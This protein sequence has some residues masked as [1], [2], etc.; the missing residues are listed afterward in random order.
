MRAPTFFTCL[1]FLFFSFFAIVVALPAE[2]VNAAVARA[3]LTGVFDKVLDARDTAKLPKSNDTVDST[4]GK[5]AAAGSDNR[6]ACPWGYGYC[7][8]TGVC[9]PIGGWCCSDSRCCSAG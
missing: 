8:N 4:E 2:P 9:C 1:C 5:T 3:D 7:S 6:V